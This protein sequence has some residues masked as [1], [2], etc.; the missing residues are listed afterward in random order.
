MEQ[1][2]L[3]KNM[4]ARVEQCRRL[5]KGVSDERTIVALRNMAAE[6][7]ADIK[8]LEAEGAQ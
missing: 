6:I 4:R 8:R 2:E 5:A 7:E 3:I 1:A